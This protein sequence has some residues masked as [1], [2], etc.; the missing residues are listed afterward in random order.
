MNTWEDLHDIMPNNSVKAYASV[1][2]SAAD[3]DLWS[4][5]I[6]EKPLPGKSSLQQI[7]LKLNSF[8]NLN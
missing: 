2:A 3:L 4:S 6:T 8:I 1:Y 5:A 7:R